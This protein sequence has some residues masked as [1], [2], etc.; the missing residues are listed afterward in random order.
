MT[1]LLWL[2]ASAADT[3]REEIRRARGNEVCFVAA[4]GEDGAIAT[5][6]AVARGNDRA[7]LAAL[8]HAPAGSIAIHNHP[9][10]QLDPSEP[11]LRI[12]AVLYQQNI[13]FAITDNDARELYVVVEPPLLTPKEALIDGEIEAVLAP[14]GPMER[15]HGAYEDRP[16]QREMARS[17]ARAY[18]EGG[19]V[20]AEAGTGTG[21]SV[22]Y[23]IPAIQWAVRNG[24]RTVVST[25]TINLQEQLVRKDL[26][27]LTR[28]MGKE[29]RFALVKGR[30][31]YVSIRRA[32]LAAQGQALLFEEPQRNALTAILEWLE[33]TADGSIQDLPFTPPPDVWDE[34]LSDSDVCLRTR[35]PHFESC[36]YQKSRREASQADILVANHHL[37]FSDLAVRRTQNNYGSSIVLPPYRRVVLDEAH[38]VEDAATEHLGAN[39]SRRGLFRVLGRLERRGKGLLPALESK[40]LAA[41]H[42]VLQQELLRQIGDDLTPRVEQARSSSHELF[43]ALEQMIASAEDGILR[44]NESFNASEAWTGGLDV[45]HQNCLL[46]LDSIARGIERLRETVHGDRR[47]AEFLNEQLIELNGILG[48]VQS[49]AEG[50]R[51]AFSPADSTVLVRWLERR[52]QTGGETNVLIRAAPI[53]LSELMR[54]TLFDRVD[55][56]ILTSATLATRAG[57]SFIRSRLGLSSGQHVREAVHASPFDYEAQARIVVP[58]DLP[59]P[60]ATDGGP[61]DRATARVVSELAAVAGGGVFVLFTSYRS[62]RTVASELRRLGVP[63]RWPLF[64]QGEAARTRLLDSFVQSGRGVLLGVNSFWEGV[65]V[66]GDPLRAIAIAK[67]P[68]KV[69]SEPLTSARIE[70]I[71]RDGGNSFVDYLLPHAVLRLKQGFGRLIRTR[72]DRGAVLLLDRRV[73]ERGYGRYFLES[74]P[75]APLL[76]GPWS[77]LRFELAEFYESKPASLAQSG[78]LP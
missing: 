65:D 34:V 76:R 50:L 29:F 46:H 11:D 77:E 51:L 68:F 74:L 49:A 60:A 27:F 8:T 35:C 41:S 36:F 39:V 31:N 71:E 44:L 48:R 19:V 15:Y 69:P 28:I 33:H 21:K 58:D 40:L 45:A 55:S 20:L 53:D 16:S 13:G 9:S 42:D 23:L 63:D 25:N 75:P 67:L 66:P 24:E 1:R 62:L 59:L 4:V 12:A 52:T 56:A 14:G 6:Q 3:I 32:R 47:W 70:A 38:N 17:V 73:L 43:T 54:E 30:H 37:L 10:G 26:P 2:T 18:N 72:T 57:F 22:A 7:V 64:V 78:R 5:V 61:Y